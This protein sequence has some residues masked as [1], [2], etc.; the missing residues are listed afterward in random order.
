MSIALRALLEAGGFIGVCVVYLGGA[1]L[2][3]GPRKRK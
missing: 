3:C 1:W 2:I